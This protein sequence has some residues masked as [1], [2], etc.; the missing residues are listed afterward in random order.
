MCSWTEHRIA[1]YLA[2]NW[3]IVQKRKVDNNGW[4]RRYYTIFIA[5]IT[6]QMN[7][8]IS[9]DNNSNNNNISVENRRHIKTCAYKR[10]KLNYKAKHSE[11]HVNRENFGA[12]NKQNNFFSLFFGKTYFYIGFYVWL[13]SGSWLVWAKSYKTSTYLIHIAFGKLSTPF[14]DDRNLFNFN[15]FFSLPTHVQIPF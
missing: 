14:V 11:K 13:D 5:Y 7:N 9:S 15:G 3:H 4:P 2:D 1:L 6:W 12:K 8:Q 10:N